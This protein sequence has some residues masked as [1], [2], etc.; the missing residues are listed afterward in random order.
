MAIWAKLV[1]EFQ[2]IQ[3]RPFELG[4]PS[5]LVPTHAQPLVEGEWMELNATY[6]MIRGAADPGAVPAFC[7]FA[8]QG[9]YETQAIQKGP[10]LYMGAYELDTKIMDAGG[11][12]VNDALEVAPV[13]IGG[14]VRRALQKLTTGHEVARVTRLPNV[15]NGFLRIMVK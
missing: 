9:R 6:K 2:S 10:F 13:S 14:I 12:A 4:D 7:Y 11:L 8:E 3:R 5:I 15:N 1:S